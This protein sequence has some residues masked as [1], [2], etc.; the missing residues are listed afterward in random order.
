MSQ[1]AM[2]DYL[3]D[4]PKTGVLIAIP[5]SK[6][7]SKTIPIEM[8]LA[9][10]VQQPPTH[11]STAYIGVQGK[12]ISKQRDYCAQAALQIG[13]KY[14]WFVDDDTVPPPN[15][16]KRL[17][18]VLDNNPDIA[19]VGG[20]Y[21]TK[22]DPPQPVVFRGMGLGSFWHWKKGD[23]FEVTGMGAGCM[24]INTE[25]FKKIG[26]PPYFPWPTN[27]SYDSSIPSTSVS[28]DISF[29]NKVRATGYRVFAHG[30]ILCDHYDRKTGELWRLPD[31][32]YPMRTDV[33][34]LG[35]GTV[36]TPVSTDG[37]FLTKNESPKDSPK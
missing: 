10:A 2:P 33:S 37:T 28:E 19:V 22:N 31:D 1:A 7:N 32:S 23:V 9:M 13:A 34:I 14:L 18:Y 27:D 36:V 25:I 30:A 17:I 26:D 11:L 35:N 24:L 21:V 12:D 6:E 8:L 4:G 29:C 16:L 5:S 15:T 20:I 3:P